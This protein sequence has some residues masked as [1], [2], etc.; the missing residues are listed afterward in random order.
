MI[1]HEPAV[2]LTDLGLALENTLFVFLLP[3]RGRDAVLGRAFRLLFAALAIAASLGFLAHGFLIDKTSPPHQLAWTATLLAI[4]VAALATTMIAARL[5]CAAPAAQWVTR[6]A[7]LLL[8]V[9]AVLVIAG[10]RRF[11]AAVTVYLP[12]I[13]FLLVAF[14]IRYRRARAP[15]ALH[16]VAGVVLS[17]VAAAVQQLGIGLHPIYLDHNALYHLIQALALGLLYLAG[18]GLLRPATAE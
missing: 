15:A 13:V 12:A 6:A 5:C 11:G 2:A 3:W 10:V 16:G 7:L 9:Y 8:L 1:L 18:R 4:G 14:G 17:L